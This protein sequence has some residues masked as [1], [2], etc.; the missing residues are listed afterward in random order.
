MNLFN[1]SEKC[2]KYA[3]Y[4]NLTHKSQSNVNVDNNLFHRIYILFNIV[5][6]GLLYYTIVLKESKKG[7]IFSLY[8]IFQITYLHNWHLCAWI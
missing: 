8:F 3:R 2:I 1:Q 5:S 7:V 6:H 4:H